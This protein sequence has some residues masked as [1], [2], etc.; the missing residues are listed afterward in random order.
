MVNA[1]LD[2]KKEYKG[3]NCW[4]YAEYSKKIINP[5]ECDLKLIEEE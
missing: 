3:I 5:G 1:K 2:Y 4:G